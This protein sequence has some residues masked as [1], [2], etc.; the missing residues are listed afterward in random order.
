MNKNLWIVIVIILLIIAGA[1]D[2][3]ANQGGD[4]MMDENDVESMEEMEDEMMDEENS[5]SD[6]ETDVMKKGADLMEVGFMKNI[7]PKSWPEPKRVMWFCSFTLLGARLV[8]V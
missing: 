6:S 8:E 4:D 5:V 3:S 1:F 7:P 2:L